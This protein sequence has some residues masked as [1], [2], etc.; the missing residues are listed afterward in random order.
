MRRCVK[1]SRL[2][3]ESQAQEGPEPRREPI[4]RPF[5]EVLADEQPLA[6]GG[7]SC[8]LK[9]LAGVVAE[10]EGVADFA[11]R[12]TGGRR[13]EIDRREATDGVVQPMDDVFGADRSV[14]G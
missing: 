1:E 2:G 8:D 14:E 7:L 10:C 9:D 12:G 4:D 11:V 3:M 13:G 5:R 6:P